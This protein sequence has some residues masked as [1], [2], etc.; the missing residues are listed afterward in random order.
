VIN[1]KQRRLISLRH[2]SNALVLHGERQQPGIG[3]AAKPTRAFTTRTQI[4]ACFVAKRLVRHLER[5][6][7]G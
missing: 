6:S 1:T 7:F 5:E 3:S 2:G 4:H